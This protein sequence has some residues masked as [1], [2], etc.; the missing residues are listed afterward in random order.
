[1][2]TH[3]AIDWTPGEKTRA[4]I[5]RGNSARMVRDVTGGWGLTIHA[6]GRRHFTAGTTPQEAAN[7]MERKLERH[8]SAEAAT[9][10]G[11]ALEGG[12]E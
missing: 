3:S 8:Y 11:E 10:S 5:D 1:M 7:M 2:T 12:E 9:G 4:L 6:A